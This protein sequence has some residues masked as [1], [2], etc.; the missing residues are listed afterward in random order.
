MMDFV[1]IKTMADL[2]NVITKEN[3]QRLSN[4]I[5]NLIQ[6]IAVIKQCTQPGETV[7]PIGALI[8]KMIT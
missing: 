2:Y 3:H 4:D 6:S 8:G 5:V 1:R 7:E